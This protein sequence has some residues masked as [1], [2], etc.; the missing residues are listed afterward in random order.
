M[1]ESTPEFV[2]IKLKEKLL[3]KLEFKELPWNKLAQVINERTRVKDKDW[4]HRMAR[5][6]FM[7]KGERAL[8]TPD[9]FDALCGYLGESP[10]LVWHDA[11]CDRYP[12]FK[13]TNLAKS[14]EDIHKVALEHQM[15]CTTNDS[16]L[17]K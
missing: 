15:S 11:V 8:M 13:K 7:P 14:Y 17:V 10:G 5:R 1:I 9:V 3:K 6:L 16:L 4:D 12:K 2:V